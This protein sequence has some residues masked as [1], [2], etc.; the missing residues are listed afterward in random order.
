VVVVLVAVLVAVAVLAVL[1]QTELHRSA[2]PV[3][4]DST[5]PPGAAKL[6]IQP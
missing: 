5:H 6:Q 3:V 4:Q 2:V 1:V